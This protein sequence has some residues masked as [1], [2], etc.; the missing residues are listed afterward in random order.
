M[1]FRTWNSNFGFFEMDNIDFTV[2]NLR[3]GPLKIVNMLDMDMSVFN[4]LGAKNGQKTCTHFW[5][6]LN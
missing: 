2:R 6:N 3:Y 4:F 1:V 5:T